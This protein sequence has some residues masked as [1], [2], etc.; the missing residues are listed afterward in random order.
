[1]SLPQI[2]RVV[3][4]PGVFHADEVCAVSWLRIWVGRQLPV[5]RRPP[6]E[7]EL[8]DPAV[9]VVDVGGRFD[10]STRCFDHHQKG[11]AGQRHPVTYRIPVGDLQIPM[12][13]FGLVFSAALPGGQN[14]TAD[15]EAVTARFEKRVVEGID[16][17]DNGWEAG[18]NL[19]ND[20]QG[21]IGI[22]GWGAPALGHKLPAG[23]PGAALSLSACISGFNPGAGATAAERDAAFEAAVAWVIPVLDNE[24]RAAKEFA[25]ARAAVLAAE[26]LVPQDSQRTTLVLRTFAPWSEHIFDRPDQAD[27][28]YVVYPS[29]RGGFCIQQVPKEP[30][31]FEGR[32][33]LPA[34]WAGLRGKALADLVGLSAHGSATFCHPGR[35]IAGAETMQDALVLARA[36]VEG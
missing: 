2:T 4:H 32:K 35:F 6:T 9:A 15:D 23:R 26:T 10:P 1:M 29:E 7:A 8:A 25:A 21:A 16:A 31:S 33:P 12:A 20:G 24:F 3:T 13:S 22:Q 11:G 19:W 18:L 28:L 5:E 27:L 17:L 14:P 34:A 30:G 36:A